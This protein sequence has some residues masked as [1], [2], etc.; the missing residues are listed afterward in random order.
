MN[1]PQDP[2]DIALDKLKTAICSLPPKPKRLVI[3]WIHKWSALLRGEKTFDPKRLLR[4]KRGD[5]LRVEFGFNVGNEYGGFHYAAVV[6]NNNSNGSGNILV[7]PLT[8]LGINELVSDIAKND[9]YLGI[10][11]IPDN[12]LGT[13]AKPSQVQ[14]I[15]K[16]RIKKPL[17]NNERIACLLPAH[18]DAIDNKIKELIIKPAN[19]KTFSINS[20]RYNIRNRRCKKSSRFCQRYQAQNKKNK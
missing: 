15:S 19:E 17:K 10:G 1:A 14:A 8:S 6:E 9:L 20:K 5:I 18:L 11:I 3:D 16:M 12:T 13:V 4:Y 2:V 7:V